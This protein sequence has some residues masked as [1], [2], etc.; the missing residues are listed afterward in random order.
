METALSGRHAGKDRDFYV[1]VAIAIYA[2]DHSTLTAS[3]LSEQEKM[4]FYLL[5][6]MSAAQSLEKRGAKLKWYNVNYPLDR[7]KISQR[8]GIQASRLFEM[9]PE[10]FSS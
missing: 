10:L 4:E 9:Y 2:Q 3:G 6:A 5:W 8:Y 1:A 7:D